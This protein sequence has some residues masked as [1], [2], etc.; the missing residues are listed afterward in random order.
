MVAR[1]ISIPAL[2]TDFSE[3]VK[4]IDEVSCPERHDALRL[5][6]TVICATE[7]ILALV[8]SVFAAKGGLAATWH[9]LQCHV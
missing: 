9:C 5:V 3:H 2:E 8:I 7:A 4:I 6:I 1:G